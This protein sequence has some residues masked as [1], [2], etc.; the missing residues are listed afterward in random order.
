MFSPQTMFELQKMVLNQVS[1]DKNLF[2]RELK[3]SFLWL[4]SSEIFQLH[5]WADENYESL[6]NTIISEVFNRKA[7]V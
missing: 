1:E 5:W 4:Q 7:I 2:Q 6:Y 3:K